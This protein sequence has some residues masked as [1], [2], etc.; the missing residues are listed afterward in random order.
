MWT[1]LKFTSIDFEE[2]RQ[3]ELLAKHM[4]WYYAKFVRS[5]WIKGQHKNCLIFLG[6]GE[7]DLASRSH[8]DPSDPGRLSPGAGYCTPQ[9][10]ILTIWY[11]CWIVCCTSENMGPW[12]ISAWTFPVV[13]K[14]RSEHIVDVG[15]NKNDLNDFSRMWIQGDIPLSAPLFCFIL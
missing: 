9:S 13:R 15:F 3:K 10:G 1:W 12:F 7:V 6:G 14:W 11:S 4:F 8:F 2:K 5:V